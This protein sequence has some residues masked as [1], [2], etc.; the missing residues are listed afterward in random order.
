MGGR[1]AGFGG[2]LTAEIYSFLLMCKGRCWCRTLSAALASC[3]RQL[4][5]P[6]LHL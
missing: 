6:R 3:V 2:Q 5:P 1:R 4:V